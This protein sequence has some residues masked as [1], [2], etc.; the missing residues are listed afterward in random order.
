MAR[1]ITQITD[2]FKEFKDNVNTISLNVGDPVNLNTEGD[3]DLVQAI[4]ELDSDINGAGGGTPS[5]DLTHNSHQ[6]TVG[7]RNLVGIINAIDGFIGDSA[8]ILPTTATTIIL[9]IK[10]LDS[11]LHGAGGGNAKA[12]M[13]TEAT[14]IVDAI[15]EIEAVFDASDTNITSPS[16]F[17]AIITGSFTV[18]AS[19]NIVLD[20]DGGNI[21]FKDGGT[22]RFAFGLGASNTLDVTGN[23]ALT[24][25]GSVSETSTTTYE[26][27][28]GTTL[29]QTSGTTFTQTSGSH[30]TRNVDGNLLDSAVGTYTVYSGGAGTVTTDGTFTVNVNGGAYTVDA[31]GDIILD[32]DGADVILKDAGTQYAAFTNSGGHLVIKTS[33]DTALTFDATNATFS[34]T[35]YTDSAL[36]TNEKSVAGGINELETAARGANTDYALTTSAQNFR[37]AIREHETDIGNMI[38]TGLSASDISAA[39]R[40]LRVELGDHTTLLTDSTTSAVLAINELHTDIGD[41]ALLDVNSVEDSVLAATD[42]VTAANYLDNRLDSVEALLDQAVLTASDVKFASVETGLV[43]RTGNFTLDVSGNITLDANGGNI[44]LRD[45]DTQY[46]ALTNTSGNLIVKSGSTTAM[47][48]SGANI[49]FAGT[50]TPPSLNTTATD[51]AAAINEHESDIGSMSLTTTA[52]DLTAAI[53]EHETDIGTMSLNT[54]ASNL[55]AAINEH[56]SDIGNMTFTGLSASDI[57]AA[58]RELRTELGDHSTLDTETTTSAVVAINELHTDIGDIAALDVQVSEEDST[59]TAADLVTAANYLD[60]RLD[61]VEALLDQAVLTTS[62]VKFTSV[63]TPLVKRTGNFTLD[64]SQ[65]II[66]DAAGGNINLKKNGTQYGA[67]VDSGSDLIIKSGT[68]TSMTFSGADITFAG[69]L[70]PPSLNTT[71]TDLAAA[72]NEHESDLGD[73]TLTGLTATNISAGLRE[74]VTEIG[75]VTTLTTTAKTSAVAGINE[76]DAELGTITSVAM[77]TSASTVSGAI[78]EHETQ[79][80]TLTSNI[81]T[82]S[83][84]EDSVYAGSKTSVVT[85]LNA[86]AALLLQLDSNSGFLDNVVGSL[87]NLSGYFDSAGATANVVAA[88]NHLGRRAINVYDASGTLLNT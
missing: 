23:Y 40:E 56:E 83:S 22:T 30:F 42:L 29:A 87:N 18:D 59:T 88:L 7:T 68:T 85:A 25:T 71:A 58:I 44:Y 33:T 46:G 1:P 65:N 12:D 26:T 36:D 76:L 15:N 43:K 4:N 64:V 5:T 35:L 37:D 13:N 2:S 66:V 53:N 81:G 52:T 6:D 14:T 50:L 41:I 57:S 80:N 16:D 77:G 51:I 3:S 75:N 72:I 62:E 82:L 45:S 55:T 39:L 31:D 48:F 32:A 67:L 11:D 24:S 54:T 73:M 74:L 19:Q 63:E 78:S 79:I 84:L 49:T 60:N 8:G 34:K 27:V 38:F 70:T 86:A 47:T 17:D 69:T 61:S 28:A 21:D 20:A 9:A 10:E